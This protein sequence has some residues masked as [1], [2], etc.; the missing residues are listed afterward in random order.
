MTIIK[1][2]VLKNKIRKLEKE[3]DKM[4]K[5]YMAHEITKEQ[6]SEFEDKNVNEIV[7]IKLAMRRA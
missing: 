3:H 1:K 2:M 5:K 6:M 4:F 7:D